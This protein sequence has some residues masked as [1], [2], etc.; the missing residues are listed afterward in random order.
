MNINF[1]KESLVTDKLIMI[2]ISHFVRNDIQWFKFRRGGLVAALPPPTP[3][4]IQKNEKT[5]HSERSEE[6]QIFSRT[7]VIKNIQQRD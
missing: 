1:Y 7:P 3:L 4:S 2:E 5:C 6:S